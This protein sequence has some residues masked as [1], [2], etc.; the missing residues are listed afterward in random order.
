LLETIN[1]ITVNNCNKTYNYQKQIHFKL[2]ILQYKSM[3]NII[4]TI[5]TTSIKINQQ[6]LNC[7]KL[8]NQNH[9]YQKEIWN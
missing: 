8:I 5:I 1:T 9:L 3:K 4:F 7:F 2:I 6:T